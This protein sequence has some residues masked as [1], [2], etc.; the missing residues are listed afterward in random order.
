MKRNKWSDLSGAGKAAVIGALAA[1]VALVGL[2]HSDLSKRADD[3]IR[4]PKWLWRMATASN[5]SFSA[6]YFLFGRR[7]NPE[8]EP[9]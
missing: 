7:T 6:A 1:H 9:V 5:A 3:E 8:L 2:A 4:G